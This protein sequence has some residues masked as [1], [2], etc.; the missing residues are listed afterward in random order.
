MSQTIF[1][2]CKKQATWKTWTNSNLWFQERPD[3]PRPSWQNPRLPSDEYALPFYTKGKYKYKHKHK[4]MQTW[5]R[6]KDN[7]PFYF[8]KMKRLTFQMV[9]DQAFGK[10]YSSPP[11]TV[12]NVLM[13]N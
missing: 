3:D 1:I 13:T 6:T 2:N 12:G 5:F 10:Y 11:E 8:V 9:Q 7:C 4:E